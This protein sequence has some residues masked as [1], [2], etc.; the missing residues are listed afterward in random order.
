MNIPKRL[1]ILSHTI[2]VDFQE[3]LWH[4]ENVWAQCNYRNNTIKIQSNTATIPRSDSQLKASFWH[5]VFHYVFYYLQKPKLEKNETLVDSIG[6]II[7]QI[8]ETME[9]G[10]S[11]GEICIPEVDARN[12]TIH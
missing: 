9:W 5:E 6:Q 7:T 4:E 10:D 3:N 8:I 2:E 11:R 1:K 12:L